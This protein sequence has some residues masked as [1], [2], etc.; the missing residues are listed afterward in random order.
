MKHNSPMSKDFGDIRVTVT[1]KKLGMARENFNL[2]WTRQEE[3]IPGKNIEVYTETGDVHVYEYNYRTHDDYYDWHDAH[4]EKR[5]DDPLAYVEYL[6]LQE[7]YRDRLAVDIA[8][9]VKVTVISTGEELYNARVP[10]GFDWSRLDGTQ[11]REMAWIRFEEDGESMYE[12]FETA[13]LKARA[14]GINADE[15]LNAIEYVG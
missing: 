11:I 14:K 15:L 9:Y 2:N 7:Y 3:Y 8:V 6:L 13:G 5:I 12:V 4:I 1:G 10:C